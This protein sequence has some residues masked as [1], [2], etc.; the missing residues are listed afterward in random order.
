MNLCHQSPAADKDFDFFDLFPVR[1]YSSYCEYGFLNH[2]V[3]KG[4]Q[5]SCPFQEIIHCQRK[6][7]SLK[8]HYTM[9]TLFAALH[10][11]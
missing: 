7:N 2:F 11:G 5:Q 3:I 6:L 4:I 10:T 1:V 8:I 9:S